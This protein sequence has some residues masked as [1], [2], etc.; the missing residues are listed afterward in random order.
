[1]IS[2]IPI[3]P[4]NFRG[5]V[6]KVLHCKIVVSEFEFHSHSKVHFRTNTLGKRKHEPDYPSAMG[7]NGI[8]AMGDNNIP[9]LWGIII[10]LLFS[11][12]DGFG[13]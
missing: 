12:R 8:I 7:D 1:M 10:S 11:Y 3:K 5:V 9:Q 6:A 13:I 4:R 2:S